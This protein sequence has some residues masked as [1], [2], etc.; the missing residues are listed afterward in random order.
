MYT[1]TPM[2]VAKGPQ[3]EKSRFTYMHGCGEKVD[4]PY[5]TWLIQGNGLNAL[6]DTG[7]SAEDYK[8]HILVKG[9]GPHMYGG[10][11]FTDVEEIKPLA[12]HLRERGLG[13]DDIDL[14]LQTH[15]DWDH[16]MNTRHFRK[17]KILLQGAEW[18]K[19]PVHPLFKGTYAPD[20]IYEEMA[21]L[22]LQFLD[23][24]YH[25]AR[26]LDL[27]F[28]PGHSPGGQSVVVDTKDGRYVIAGMCTI[29]ENFFPSEETKA[30]TGLPV[31]PTGS[32]MDPIQVYES[33]LRIM[34]AGDHVLPFHD[35]AN[36]T[37]G[38]LG[39]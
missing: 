34:K 32:H 5:T 4:V 26:G 14:V 13:Y 18:A 2:V 15:V 23:G 21:K 12:E 7:C 37:M 25:V 31:I 24:D 22:N 39:G 17:S 28:T 9:S 10:E 36:F 3:R 38:T 20:Y 33:M 35:H 16:C 6:V 8:A 11:R 1:I 29:R 19:L 27:I 30:S